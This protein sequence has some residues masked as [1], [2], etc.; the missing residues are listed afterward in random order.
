M[1][2]LRKSDDRGRTDLGWLQSRHTFSFGGY[3][4]PQH[5]HFGPLRV[6]ND[7]RVAGGGGFPTHPHRDMEIFSYVVEGVLE[8][9]D[10]LGHGGIIRAGGVQRITAGRGIAHSEFNPSP[11]DPVHFLQIWIQPRARGLEPG[12]ADAHFSREERRN[13]LRPLLSPDGR[14][15][16][17]TLQQDAVVYGT[18]LEAGHNL[19]TTPA[20][21]RIGWLHVVR[22]TLQLNGHV[23]SGGDGAAVEAEPSLEFLATAE[24]EF[25]WMDLPPA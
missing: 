9:R 8:H 16:S 18:I 11:N 5:H 4:D 10:S 1:I 12:Y 3:Q 23:L 6:I 17:L 14:G 25:L 21:G 15:G 20:P 19:R 2:T 22:G 7:D 24:S 13:Q